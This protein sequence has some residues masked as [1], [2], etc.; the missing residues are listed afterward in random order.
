MLSALPNHHE[1]VDHID[2]LTLSRRVKHARL[3]GLSPAER[4]TA[5]WTGDLHGVVRPAFYEFD[6]LTTRLSDAVALMSDRNLLGGWAAL[7]AQGNTWFD[8]QDRHGNP[9][10]VLIH[11]LPGSQLRARRGI[12][13]S[14]GLVHPDEVI[15]LGNYQVATMARAAFDEMCRAS[16]LRDAVVALDMATSTTSG[17]PHTS[18]AAVD[19]VIRSHYKVRGMV[20]ARKAITVGSARSASPGETRTRLIAHLDAGLTGLLVNQPVFDETGTLLG[21]ADLLDEEVGLVIESDGADFHSG[22]RTK[23]NHRQERFERSHLVVCRVTGDDHRDRYGTAARIL[24]ARRDAS[25]ER[26]RRWTTIKP[27]WWPSWR[28]ASRWD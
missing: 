9:D 21:I 7:R 14:E 4:R 6:A 18:V 11:C 17:V 19:R 10:E 27:D 16:G 12:R 15:D 13:P 3:A 22:P 23:D 24:A 25:R 28:H 2:P 8:G 20:Q 1:R 5:L 26:D